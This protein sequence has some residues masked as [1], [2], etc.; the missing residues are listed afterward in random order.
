[1]K[2]KKFAQSCLMIDYKNVRILVDPGSVDYFDGLLDLWTSINIIIVTHKHADHC[3]AGVIKRI[4][5][6]DNAVL[7][8]TKEV[9]NAY[10]DLK[11]ITVKSGDKINFSNKFSILI[12]KSVHGYLPF[13]KDN[14]VKEN[15]GLIID[16][17]INNVYITGDTLSFNNNYKCD[18]LFI[19]FS[20][21]GITTGIYDGLM[22][23]KETGAKV[24]VPMNLED[25][26][27]PTNQ[28]ALIEEAY[29]FKLK[30]NLMKTNDIIEIGEI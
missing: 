3:H 22:F 11:G 8:T 18:Y 10:P 29:K 25:R 1:M 15:I 4:I 28:N 21:H 7:Y 14:E 24:I 23:A 30:L 5:E 26:T 12:T 6:R 20:N 2:I 19:P 16:D 13:M 9:L 27:Y 17:S